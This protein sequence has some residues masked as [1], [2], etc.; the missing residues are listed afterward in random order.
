VL[1]SN[2]WPDGKSMAFNDFSQPGEIEGIE[3]LDLAPHKISIML[4]SE[5]FYA[6]SWSPEGKYMVAIAQS[7][8]RMMLYS[9]QTGT[10]KDL[11]EFEF[12]WGYWGWSADS[13]SIYFVV[14]EPEP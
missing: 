7:P 8:S 10:S 1:A 12:P 6:P 11:R 13:K 9:A 5:G 14:K 3:V 2:W 4:G